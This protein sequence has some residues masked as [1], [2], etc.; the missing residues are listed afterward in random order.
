[1]LLDDGFRRIQGTGYLVLSSHS[2]RTVRLGLKLSFNL[3]T[4]TNTN[5]AGTILPRRKRPLKLK[6]FVVLFYCVK[7]YV[8]CK[9]CPRWEVGE[10][11]KTDVCPRQCILL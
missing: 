2:D 3:R 6:R 9:S 4:N 10:S 7:Q 5:I 8:V 1:M 11:T